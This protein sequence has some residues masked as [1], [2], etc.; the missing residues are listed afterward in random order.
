[1]PRADPLRNG[2]LCDLSVGLGAQG[3]AGGGGSSIIRSI[4]LGRLPV[5]SGRAKVRIDLQTHL[6]AQS[7]CCWFKERPLV[8][9]MQAP[10]SAIWGILAASTDPSST[11]TTTEADDCAII[12]PLAPNQQ[13]DE[14]EVLAC[15]TAESC[16]LLCP[17][18]PLPP[19]ATRHFILKPYDQ[20]LF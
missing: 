19:S 14:H 7:I 1:M 16:V 3:Q 8:Y 9:W 10:R 13:R 4:I 18:I 17:A 20:M 11:E 12:Q 15:V 2:P 6:I 5:G